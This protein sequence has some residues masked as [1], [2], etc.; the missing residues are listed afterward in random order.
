MGLINFQRPV[1]AKADLEELLYV[2][3]LHQTSFNTRQ[4][5]TVLAEDIKHYLI[6]RHGIVVSSETVADVILS[7]FGIGCGTILIID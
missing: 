7:G 4:H 6:S 1:G 2:S 5:G 3:A